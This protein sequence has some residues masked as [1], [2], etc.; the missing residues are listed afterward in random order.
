MKLVKMTNIRTELIS[1]L[2]NLVDFEAVLSVDK[3]QTKGQL[4]KGWGGQGSNP[5]RYEI[6]ER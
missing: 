2:L 3:A 6:G 1:S 4:E 5:D